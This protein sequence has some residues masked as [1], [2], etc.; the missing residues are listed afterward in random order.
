MWLRRRAQFSSMDDRLYTSVLMEGRPPISCSWAVK[1]KCGLRSIAGT[2]R[3][4]GGL[5]IYST[6][7]LGELPKTTGAVE[8]VYLPIVVRGVAVHHLGTVGKHCAVGEVA[9]LQSATHAHED[10][11][12][13]RTL[14]TRQLC[15]EKCYDHMTTIA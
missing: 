11:P 5:R 9:E 15:D 14:E 6:L 13:L 4:S 2:H 12:Q 8:L 1:P 10:I 7:L 3:V